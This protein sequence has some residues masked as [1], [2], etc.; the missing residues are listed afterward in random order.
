MSAIPDYRTYTLE[1]LHD[2]IRNIN[3]EVYP[4]RYA[5][6][7][8][9]LREREE[10]AGIEEKDEESFFYTGVSSDARARLRR[11]RSTLIG[12]AVLLGLSAAYGVMIALGKIAQGDDLLPSALMLGVAVIGIIAAILIGRG[13]PRG[14]LFGLI[15][16]I[17]M[18]IRLESPGL[19]YSFHSFIDTFLHTRFMVGIGTMMFGLNPIGAIILVVIIVSLNNATRRN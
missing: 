6:A 15:A 10:E 2:V 3:R 1:Q 4:E 18:T 19:D 14:I 12:A 16:A 5:L 7:L 13:S 8:R 11:S 17:G 9:E